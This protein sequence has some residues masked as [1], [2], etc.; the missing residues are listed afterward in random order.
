MKTFKELRNELTN[1]EHSL[2]KHDSR[3]GVWQHQRKVTPENKD[4]VLKAYQE[5]EPKAHFQVSKTRP[6]APPKVRGHYLSDV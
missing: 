4:E 6:V 2:W 3:S 1:E 5:D